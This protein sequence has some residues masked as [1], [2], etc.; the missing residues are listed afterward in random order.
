M[1]TRFTKLFFTS[2]F[3]FCSLLLHWIPSNA[4][5][6]DFQFEHLTVKNGLS[7]NRVLS[8]IQ[9]KQGFY[10][11]ATADGLNRFDGSSFKIFRNHRNDSLSIGHNTCGDVLEG[12]DGDIWVATAGGVSRYEKA[13]GI[14]K[15]YFFHHPSFNDNIL[16]SVNELAKDRDGNV[17][18]SSHGLWK[19]NPV[20][21]TTT[22]FLFNQDD[23]AS[24]SD[25][26]PLFNVDFDVA[27][28]GLWMTTDSAINFFDIQTEKFSHHRNL[29]PRDWQVFKLKDKRPLF[30]IADDWFWAYDKES[31]LLYR[32]DSFLKNWASVHLSFTHAVSN[33]SVDSEGNPIF[34]FELVPA[35]LYNWSLKRIESLPKPRTGS[36]VFFSGVANSICLDRHHNQWLCTEDGLYVI[37]HDANLLQSFSLGAD[38]SGFPNSIY[39][40]AIHGD[41]LWLQIRNGFFKYH[42]AQRTLSPVPEFRNKPVRVL[43]NAGDTLLWVSRKNEILSI[44]FGTADVVSKTSI[45]GD[46][47]FAFA[48]KQK[49]M[50]VGTWENGLYELDGRGAMINHYHEANGLP[51]NYLVCGWYDGDRE[52]W[53][54]MNGAKGFAKLDLLTRKIES[55]LIATQGKSTID[56]NTVSAILRDGSGNL[57]LGTH[58]GGI[59]YF[60][61]RRN[62]FQ[63]FQ[64]SDGLTDDYVNTLAFDSLGNLWISTASGIDIMDLKTKSFRHVSE[65]MGQV[66]SDH[67]SNLAIAHNGTFFYTANNKIVAILPEQYT[68]A[69]PEATIVISGFNVPDRYM[70]PLST[71]LPVILSYHQNFFSVEFSALRVSPELPVKYK[72]Q[73]VGFDKDWVYS[74]TRGFANFTNVPPGSYTLQ[75][76][77]TNETGKWNDKPMAISLVIKPPFWRTW[78]FY[79]LSTLSVGCTILLVIKSRVNQF[80]KRQQEQ[81]RLIVTTQEKEKKNISAELHDDLGVRLSA[82]KYFVTSLRK[83]MPRDDKQAQEIFDKTIATIDESVEDVRYLLISLSPKTLSEYG[84]LVAVEDLVNKLSQLHITNISLQQNG[85]EERLP[86]DVE[87]GLYRITQELI[88]N[89][90]KHAGASSIHLNIEKTNGSIELCYVDDGRGFDPTKTGGGYG[91]DNIH[92]RVALLNGKVQWD[93]GVNKPTKVTIVIPC[94][95]T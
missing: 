51:F 19:I 24:V 80:K 46:P 53:L 16:N 32:F 42:I 73:L 85:M 31:D 48:D 17:W 4:Q 38:S 88:N 90:L 92:T 91:I 79:L 1:R 8:M 35:V 47:Y 6:P 68:T 23:V 56:F 13:K 20:T 76:N 37:K 54:G 77:A 12:N 2:R 55:F 29:G 84:Y 87:S 78:W 25:R 75:L 64:R 52:L 9:D 11:I 61:R 10:W 15:N 59:Y 3:F 82:L 86:Q 94:N 41:N 14:F 83:Y 58:G 22:G 50:W 5:A 21:G 26:S 89:T 44:D 7:S 18:A 43:L 30:A 70:P 34:S 45:E 39:S 72:Y 27:N 95:H 62:Q 66:N 33:F 71:G 60:D 40:L 36:V 74:N 63:N 67:I 57:W 28:N 69:A 93:T 49:H 65:T 81:M